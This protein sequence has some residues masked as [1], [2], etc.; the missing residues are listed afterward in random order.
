[1][2]DHYG[3]PGQQYPP[4]NQPPG[5]LPPGQLVM[6][7][8]QLSG[9]FQMG[10]TPMLT[11]DQWQVP[12]RL[13]QNVIPI[14]PGRHLIQAK[15]QYLFAYGAAQTEIEVA[16]GQQVELFYAQPMLTFVKG[17]IGFTPQKPPAMGC[18][19]AILVTLGLCLVAVILVAVLAG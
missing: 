4:L 2:S 17:A 11:I 8:R 12:V 3:P 10:A 5:N 15:T 16:P 6:N 18:M 1:M 13:G 9:M 19:I 14:P 7:F